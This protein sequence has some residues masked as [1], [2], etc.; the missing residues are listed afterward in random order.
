MRFA[1]IAVFAPLFLFSWIANAACAVD[2]DG[3]P[4]LAH[5]GVVEVRAACNAGVLDDCVSSPVLTAAQSPQPD[6][7]SWLAAQGPAAAAPRF[8][9]SAAWDR[10]PALRS[11]AQYYLPAESPLR[12]SLRLLI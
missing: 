10:A 2:L 7:A 6:D 4:N 9:A 8:V 12:R 5:H 11:P 1:A 3:L